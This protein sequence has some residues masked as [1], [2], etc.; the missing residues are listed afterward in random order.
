MAAALAAAPTVAQSQ[1]SAAVWENYDFVPGSKVLFY[2]DFSEDRVGNFA[3]GLRYVDGPLEVVERGGS[4][5]LRATGRS[6]FLIPIRGKLPERFTL[7]FDVIAYSTSE[8]D[9]VMFEGGRELER[10]AESANVA[11]NLTGPFILGGRANSDAPINASM[12]EALV[13]A[14]VGKVTHL[15]VLM[16]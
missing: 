6:Q 9:L 12:P 13:E 8:G 16:D 1:S 4:K 3:R 15:R 5:A 2:T 11:W 14:V 7:E 10:G